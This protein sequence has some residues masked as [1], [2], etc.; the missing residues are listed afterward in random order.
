MKSFLV[1]SFFN[2]DEPQS[3]IFGM[4]NALKTC[5]AQRNVSDKRLKI[6]AVDDEA[7]TRMA[8]A[9]VLKR[10]GHQATIT[11]SAEEALKA[12]ED[13]AV[14][15]DLVIT[16]HTMPGLSG[17]ELVKKLRAKAF[18]GEIFVLSAHAD[19]AAESEYRK[20]GVAGIMS[21]PFELTALR[22]WIQCIP[23]CDA[24]LAA[25]EKPLCDTS[26]MAFC[27]RKQ[28]I[29]GSDKRRSQ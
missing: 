3:S 19:V 4:T 20:M 2:G 25:G 13:A 10:D 24:L 1:A 23:R 11:Q 26:A 12:V 8:I 16:D 14:P 7:G 9:L 17:V 28:S 27:W 5:V 29:S 21:K 6:L 15:F 18:A 22:Q